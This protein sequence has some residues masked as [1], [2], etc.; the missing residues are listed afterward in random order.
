MGT[1]SNFNDMS[2]PR[3]M[4]KVGNAG[5]TGSVEIVEMLFTVKGPT[6]GAILMEWNV[7]SS[8]QGNAGMWDSHFRVGGAKGSDLDMG[9]CAKLQGNVVENCIAASLLFHVTKSGSGYFENVWVWT[10]DQ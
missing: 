1:G 8:G 6:K 2:K 5:D 10:A 4:V 9:L 7:K 3:V